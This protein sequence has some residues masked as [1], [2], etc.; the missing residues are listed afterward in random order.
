MRMKVPIALTFVFLWCVVAQAQCSGG[1]C[2]VPSYTVQQP[3]FMTVETPTPTVVDKPA[4]VPG[5]LGG[6]CLARSDVPA[7]IVLPAAKVEK[8]KSAPIVPV[9]HT[10]APPQVAHVEGTF[11]Y[12]EGYYYSPRR[13]GLFRGIGRALFGPG[14]RHRARCC[15]R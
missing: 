14:K 13:R 15:Q 12:Q 10:A 7:P 4:M 1:R 8:E 9:K 5:P 6:F 2:V 11:V 3:T